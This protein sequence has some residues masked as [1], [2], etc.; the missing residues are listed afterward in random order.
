MIEIPVIMSDFGID[1][2]VLNGYNRYNNLKT[3]LYVSDRKNKEEW[4]NDKQKL[5]GKVL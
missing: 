5:S 4:Q 2:S 1:K 3:A